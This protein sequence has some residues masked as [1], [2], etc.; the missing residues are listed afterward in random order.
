MLAPKFNMLS[1]FLLVGMI[2]S[3][4]AYVKATKEFAQ[5]VEKHRILQSYAR[6]LIVEDDT[7]IVAVRKN[8]AYFGNFAWE[9]F[10]PK[11][12]AYRLFY[13]SR[14]EQNQQSNLHRPSYFDLSPGRHI[15]EYSTRSNFEQSAIGITE[16]PP[17]SR[18]LLDEKLE[19]TEPVFEWQGK[20]GDQDG[21]IQELS[22]CVSNKALVIISGRNNQGPLMW[23]DSD[24]PVNQ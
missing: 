18:L 22:V 20:I 5:I 13:L 7:Q 2:A 6:E 4:I 9:V 1:V 14:N 19:S 17:V 12:H 24:T 16:S 10:I 23:I 8:F 15:I 11:G 3:A 21:S